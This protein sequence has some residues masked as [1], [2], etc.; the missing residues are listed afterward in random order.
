MSRESTDGSRVNQ[1]LKHAIETL[2][3]DR[4]VAYHPIITRVVGSATAG[5]FLS[6][7]LYWTPRTQDPEGWVYKTQED[8]LE[9][10]GLTRS[11]QETAR[12]VLRGA[13]VMEEVKK[14]L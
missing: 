3:T 11:E 2:L 5:I 6:Q 4:P 13:M 14:G 9:E 12:R 10:T 8:I 7:L 1:P